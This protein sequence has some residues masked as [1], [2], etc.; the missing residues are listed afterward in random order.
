VKSVLP[1]DDTDRD[2]QDAIEM[3][4]DGKFCL[5]DDELTERYF[6]RFSGHGVE[7]WE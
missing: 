1:F 5:P 7:V 4:G 6:S 3:D 2:Y